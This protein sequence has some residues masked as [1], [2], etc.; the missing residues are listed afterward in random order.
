[1]EKQGPSSKMH[2]QSFRKEAPALVQGPSLKKQAESLIKIQDESLD[3]VVPSLKTASLKKEAPSFK[4]RGLSLKKQAESLNKMRAGSLPA[5]SE[6]LSSEIQA[7]PLKNH[8]PSLR[9][10]NSRQVL[11]C[12]AFLRKGK[13][14]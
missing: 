13:P 14:R 3:D 12:V 10:I 4:K 7:E 5:E 11:N 8:G 2:A 9:K 6:V 1:M